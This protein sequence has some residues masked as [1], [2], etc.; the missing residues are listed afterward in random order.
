MR[1]V[2]VLMLMMLA[3]IVVVG[4]ARLPEVG[5]YVC[6]WTSSYRFIGTILSQGDDLISLNCTQIYHLNFAGGLLDDTCQDFDGKMICI[7][8]SQIQYMVWYPSQ[9]VKS[10]SA[11]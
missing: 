10:S 8:K 2:A 5:D 9:S 6:I 7:S 11:Q 3:G 4:D 1:L